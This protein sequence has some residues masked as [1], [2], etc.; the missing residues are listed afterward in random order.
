MCSAAAAWDNA[1]FAEEYDAMSEERRLYPEDQARVDAYLKDG[2]NSVE[3][4]PFRP[5][6]LMIMLAVVVTLFTGMSMVIARVA[7][8]Y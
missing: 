8:I 5:M 2:F 4:K 3:R 7:G 6:R 1:A